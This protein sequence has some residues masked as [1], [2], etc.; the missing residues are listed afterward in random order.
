MAFHKLI[1]YIKRRK[2]SNLGLNNSSN[3][4]LTLPK[5]VR[6]FF[7]VSRGLH[8]IHMHIEMA[9]YMWLAKAKSV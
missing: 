4:G 5:S 3:Q 7:M 6:L 1:K 8:C 2:D 9:P